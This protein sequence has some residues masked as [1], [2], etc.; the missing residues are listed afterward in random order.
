MLV[1]AVDGVVLGVP[2]GQGL[3]RTKAGQR[4]LAKKES[5]LRDKY[6]ED[7]HAGRRWLPFYY[8]GEDISAYVPQI[9]YFI[10]GEQRFDS[11]DAALAFAKDTAA[12]A[13]TATFAARGH[14]DSSRRSRRRPTSWSSRAATRRAARRAGSCGSSR[15]TGPASGT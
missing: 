1:V 4:L 3:L 8:Q 11:V 14:G 6:S 5:R 13:R 7:L 12:T 2:C 10:E 9:L 15:P